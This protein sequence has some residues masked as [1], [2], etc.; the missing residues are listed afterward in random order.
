M[1]Q[2]DRIVDISITRQTQQIDIASFDIP[3]LLVRV[4]TS[5]VS[6]PSRVMTFTSAEAVADI[7]GT[8]HSAY[9]MAV[10]LSSGDQKP[11]EFKVGA[12]RYS[13]AA[14]QGIVTG[15]VEPVGVL[16]PP[17]T[18]AVTTQP[19]NGD[20]V[21]DVDGG[22][23][24][25]GDLNYSG[26]DTFDVT[27]TDSES[28]TEVVTVPVQVTAP[29]QPSESYVEGLLESLEADDTWYALTIDSKFD[30]DIL[31]VAEVIQ[32]Q[33]RVFF[34]S[35]SSN[36]LLDTLSTTD[37]GSL[38]QERGFTRT[39]L[40]YSPSAES[41]HPEVV[42]VGSQIVET[43]G[44]NTWEYKRLPSVSINRLSDTDINTLEGK[45]VN[46]YVTIKGAPVTRRGVSADGSWIDEINENSLLAA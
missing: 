5:Q 3:L 26:T 7:F 45:G 15:D 46:Y 18:Y 27:I 37:V 1:A 17:L 9:R 29:P 12:V 20:V 11:A 44:S 6:M 34:T 41:Q 40:M 4:D 16:V 24:Y 43:P 31:S 22:Y 33:R 35:S 30:Q 13:T 28:S 32:S 2:I 14:T 42:W 36:A 38:L 8:S 19:T 23:T 10:A 39:V 21:M 25:T